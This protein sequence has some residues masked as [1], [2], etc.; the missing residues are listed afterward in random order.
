MTHVDAKKAGHPM[1]II[2]VVGHGDD[3]RDDVLLGPIRS[4]LLNLGIFKR[5]SMKNSAK[6]FLEFF[7]TQINAI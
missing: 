3:L 2:L 5:F 4:E 1:K 7:F 6:M